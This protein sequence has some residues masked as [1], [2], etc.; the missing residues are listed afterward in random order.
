MS[1]DNGIYIAKFLDGYKVI[2]TTNI[3]DLN[4]YPEGS[5]E[6]IKVWKEF[7]ERAKTFKTHSE[8]VHHAYEIYRTM[9]YVEYGICDL[10]E[11]VEF[12]PFNAAIKRGTSL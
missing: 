12:D 5:K 6:N 8:A 10:G 1:A 3:D 11:G 4:Y 2:H 7:F 9:T